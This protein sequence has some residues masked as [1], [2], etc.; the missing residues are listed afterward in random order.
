MGTELAGAL[1]G[2]F[3]I[4]SKLKPATRMQQPQA[5]QQKQ[6]ATRNQKQPEA[7]NKLEPAKAWSPQQQQ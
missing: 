4:G 7:S 6:R 5:S 2:T 1:S 3:S